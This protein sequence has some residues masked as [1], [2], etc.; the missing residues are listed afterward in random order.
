MTLQHHLQNLQC[1]PKRLNN[2]GAHT[3]TNAH[4]EIKEIKAVYFSRCSAGLLE[5]Q[6]A[7]IQETTI[8][9]T[10]CSCNTA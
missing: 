8:K 9:K 7:H 5:L 2:L 3:Q 10:K 4:L 6:W 1:L